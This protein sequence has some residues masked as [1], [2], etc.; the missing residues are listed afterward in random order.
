MAA[1]LLL[2]A[3]WSIAAVQIALFSLQS[4]DGP[5]DAALVLGAAAWGN[6]PSPVYRERI[7]KAIELYEQ[8][9][10]RRIVLTGGSPVRAYPAEA[11]VG[12][13]YCLLHG[14]PDDTLLV[15]DRSRTTWSNLNDAQPLMSGAEIRTV[16]LVSDPL[17][18][19]RA[20]AMA[21]AQGIDAQPAPTTTTRFRSWR[22]RAGLLWHEAWSYLAF[23][24]LGWQD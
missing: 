9:R 12:R 18:M 15:E 23:V 6:R 10:V 13:R 11:Q 16:L 19:K 4:S 2:A 21:H 5:A 14:I 24:T 1:L 3:L 22:T 17:H 7:L 8:H 20:I